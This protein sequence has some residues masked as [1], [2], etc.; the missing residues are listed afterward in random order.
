M[1]YAYLSQQLRPP[2]QAVFEQAELY[3]NLTEQPEQEIQDALL[4]L[5][6]VLYTAQEE[7][8]SL[9]QIV[10]TDIDQF[11]KEYFGKERFG[12]LIRSIPERLYRLG[13]LIFFVEVFYF[14]GDWLF[15]EIQPQMA[16]FLYLYG[17]GA[18]F[19]LIP[20]AH[21]LYRLLSW[22]KEIKL[23]HVYGT[24][25]VL[26]G[27]LLW[28]GLYLNQKI[29]LQ[30]PRFWLMLV[31]GTYLLGYKGFEIYRNQNRFG[32]WKNP[33]EEALKSTLKAEKKNF[34][35]LLTKQEIEKAYAKE[36]RRKAKKGMTS[37]VFYQKV[38]KSIQKEERL[39]KW[40]WAY[41]VGFSFLFAL[42]SYFQDPLTDALIFTVFELLV[43]GLVMSGF[44]KLL[45]H[46][47][48]A[49]KQ[50]VQEAAPSQE[51]LE[52]YFHQLGI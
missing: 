52:S 1:S 41:V 29:D 4:N 15:F 45:Q 25:L 50:F 49:R 9:E 28:L 46:G 19:L 7:G 33:E 12:G 51:D 39:I 6:D 23:V 20:V 31:I 42:P 3:A 43:C 37:Q 11:C 21:L 10:G 18:G 47:L 24:M 30:A 35:A 13:K 2:Y 48:V 40:K 8:K 5:F 44:V 34:Q 32:S 17:I 26:T 22:K 38:E 14:V 16:I 27:L 36:F